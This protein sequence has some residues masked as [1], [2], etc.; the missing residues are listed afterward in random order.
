MRTLVKKLTAD[1]GE[2][3]KAAVSRVRLSA[4]VHTRVM[5]RLPNEIAI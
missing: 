2:D 5:A 1:V 4:L 3:F